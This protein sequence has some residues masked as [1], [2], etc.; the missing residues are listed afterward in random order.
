MKTKTPTF[1]KL[2]IA[3]VV[4]QATKTVTEFPWH[5]VFFAG[6]HTDNSGKTHTYTRDDLQ[7]VVDN[8]VANKAPLVIGHPEL[9]APAYGWVSDVRLTDDDRLEIKADN[10]N[11]EFAKSVAAKAYPNRSVSLVR[12]GKGLSLRHVGYLGAAEPALENLGWQFS[13][14][15]NDQA[16]TIEFSLETAQHRSIL[17]MFSNLRDFFIDKFSLEEADRVLP[18][19]T[20]NWMRDRVAKDE[21][22]NPDE[23]FLY[24]K[25]T[26]PLEDDVNKFTQADLD[27]A[28][29]QAVDTAKAEFS[30][31]L[32]DAEKRA[33]DAEKK[34]DAQA[35]SRRVADCQTV[36][37]AKVQAGALTPAQAIGLAEFMASLPQ[38]DDA[39]TFSFSKADK[40]TVEQS[41]YDFAKSFVDGLGAKSPLG[42]EP[43]LGSEKDLDEKA[44][45]YSKAHGVSYADAV[46]AVSQG[47]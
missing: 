46:I 34:L 47:A 24:N 7:Q 39:Q 36:V 13:V 40:S 45:E 10:V 19:W 22:Q 20:L 14:D 15:E 35:Y 38:G 32:S 17:D 42:N 16:E 41:Q 3:S 11:V 12:T 43:E 26:D 25:P 18:E 33:A 23:D 5:D 6:T 37:D 2:P 9:D 30:N 1:K 31:Q 28:V 27:A 44:E 21:A 4:E 8:F 29:K